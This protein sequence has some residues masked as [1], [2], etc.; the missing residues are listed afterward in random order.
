VSER[1]PSLL[2]SQ[3]LHLVLA[4]NCPAGH[5]VALLIFTEKC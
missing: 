2:M 1:S 4:A 5:A 3:L